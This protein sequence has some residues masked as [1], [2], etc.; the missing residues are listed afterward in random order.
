MPTSVTRSSP[1]SASDVQ[2]HTSREACESA[3][4]SARAVHSIAQSLA[5]G[6]VVV[7][8]LVVCGCGERWQAVTYPT[9]GRLVIN[10][11][12]PVGAVVELHNEGA[13]ADV[14]NSRP[15]GIVDESGAFHLTTYLANDGAP[16]GQYRVTIKWPPDVS[17]PSLADRLNHAYASPESSKWTVTIEEH[18]TDLG[19]IAVEAAKVL[20][21]DRAVARHAPAGPGMGRR[22]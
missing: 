16:P 22:K 17:R 21:A 5:L 1:L 4:H 9:H 20:P 19:T 14:R 7:S 6:G 12:V 3:T 10:G 15:W 2:P 18:E 8:L 11:Q 13:E